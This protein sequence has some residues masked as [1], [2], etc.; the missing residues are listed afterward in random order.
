M[1]LIMCRLALSLYCFFIGPAVGQYY[2][3][4]YNCFQL[5]VQLF[6]LYV[7]TCCRIKVDCFMN[8]FY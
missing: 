3:K 6:Y 4:I 2:V 5:H 7:Y 1:H 8:T